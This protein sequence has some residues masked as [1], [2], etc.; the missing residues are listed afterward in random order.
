MILNEW[1]YLSGRRY[2]Q[3]IDLANIKNI[4]LFIFLR[5]VLLK[6]W[7]ELSKAPLSED[8]AGL[9]LTS[10]SSPYS[11]VSGIEGT[12]GAGGGGGT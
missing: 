3:C 7:I 4:Q 1:S 6:P 5:P 10:S 9:E 12:G 8:A 11:S 2:N